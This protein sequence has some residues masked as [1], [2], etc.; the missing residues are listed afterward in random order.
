M[1]ETWASGELCLLSDVASMSSMS[2]LLG[3]APQDASA[4]L[5][6]K[7]WCHTMCPLVL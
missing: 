1:R 6:V 7:N 4:R 3:T 5:L 2:W